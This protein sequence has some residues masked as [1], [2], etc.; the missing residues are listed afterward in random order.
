MGLSLSLQE[1]SSA[2]EI[3][4]EGDVFEVPI[5]IKKMKSEKAYRESQLTMIVSIICALL[6]SDG[7]WKVK[8]RV[9]RS[10]YFK[11]WDRWYFKNDWTAF[12]RHYWILFILRQSKNPKK[13]RQTVGFHGRLL[14]VIMHCGLQSLSSNSKPGHTHFTMGASR[15]SW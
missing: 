4:M 10:S 14:A 1:L 15:E 12:S 8:H 9:G 2:K 11:K 3:K 5:S 6:N 7:A 13:E